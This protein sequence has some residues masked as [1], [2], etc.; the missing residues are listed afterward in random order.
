MLLTVDIGNTNLTFAIMNNGKAVATYRLTTTIKRTSDE[1]GFQIMNMLNINSLDVSDIHGIIVSS[2]VPKIMHSFTNAIRKY[3]GKEPMI[4]GPGVKSGISIRY[5]NPKEVGADRIVDAVAAHNCYGGDLLVIDFGTATTFEYVDSKANYY[6]GCIC[7]GIEI[8]GQALSNM[9]AKLPE[10]EI[11]PTEK[12]IASDTIGAMQSGLFYGY[13]GQVEYLIEKF[14]KEIG[15]DL[16]VIATGGLG[17]QIAKAT[18]KID[19]YDPNLAFKG[20]E[21]IYRKNSVQG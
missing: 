1:Y 17:K 14:K 5:D 3:L 13:V 19:I 18:S 16:K 6:G 10:I 7:P 2:V 4:V 11:K 20:L 12:V 9:A 8:A 15:K 21:I